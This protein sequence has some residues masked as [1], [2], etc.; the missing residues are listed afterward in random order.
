MKALIITEFMLVALN[1]FSQTAVYLPP[2]WLDRI[3]KTNQGIEE[4]C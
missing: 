2:K 1:G 3:V 4:H